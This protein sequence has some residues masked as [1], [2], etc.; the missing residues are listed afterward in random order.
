MGSWI[1]QR[2]KPY[3]F[4]TVMSL[5]FNF[6]T[7]QVQMKVMMN[8]GQRLMHW[9]TGAPFCLY[10]TVKGYQD[11]TSLGMMMTIIILRYDG[12][13]NNGLTILAVSCR[14]LLTVAH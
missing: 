9:T 1:L 5:N 3:G 8:V 7:M 4:C 11:D 6:S 12:D 13:N 2:A 14:N 10:N